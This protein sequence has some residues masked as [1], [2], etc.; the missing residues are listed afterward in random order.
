MSYMGKAVREAKVHT[1]WTEPDEG[2]EKALERFIAVLFENPLFMNDLEAFAAPLIHPGRVNSLAQ[3]LVKLTAP[4]VPDLYQGTE[5]WDLSLVDP[6]NRRPVD[7]P[8]RRAMLRELEASC[9]TPP[10]GESLAA[11]DGSSPE[12][13]QSRMDEGLPK[14]WLIRQALSL[15]KHH[16]ECFEVNSS[17]EPIAVTGAKERHALCFARSGRVVV[18]IPRFPL[19][20]GGD[21]QDTSVVLPRGTWTDL[22]S[23][24]VWKGGTAAVSS[25][26]GSF[27]V[28]LLFRDLRNS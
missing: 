5:L 19:L 15:R 9:P 18:L 21:W 7:Y 23:G 28:A 17:Y 13:I 3:T 26:L 2:Y 27:P 10:L 1:S 22:L 4:G 6:D 8:L 14:L 20:L 12:T 24:R 11:P 25:L 16:P